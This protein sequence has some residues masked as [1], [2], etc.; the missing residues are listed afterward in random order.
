MMLTQDRETLGAVDYA[1]LNS[2]IQETFAALDRFEWQAIEELS[3]M[4]D[5]CY[6]KDAGQRALK[7]I[8]KTS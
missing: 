4:R 5:N 6:Y 2:S 1:N 8:A 3:V 7:T